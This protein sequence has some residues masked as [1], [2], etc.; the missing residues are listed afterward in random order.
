MGRVIDS[1]KWRY[2]NVAL[3]WATTRVGPT[4]SHRSGK[5]LIR[6]ET[7]VAKQFFNEDLG[8]AAATGVW[9]VHHLNPVRVRCLSCGQMTNPAASS[10]TCDCGRPVPE[11]PPYW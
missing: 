2:Q 10:G 3:P 1:R 11:S 8:A 5:P 9:R 6:R 4:D 7:D